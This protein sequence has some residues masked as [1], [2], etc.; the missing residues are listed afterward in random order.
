MKNK[1][2]IRADA[3]KNIGMGHIMRC[4][5][6]AH[7]L[8][9]V[10]C[11]FLVSDYESYKIIN[12]NDLEGIC[13]NSNYNNLLISEVKKILKIGRENYVNSILVDSYYVTKEYLEELKKYFYV[14]C[15]N[16]SNNYLPADYIINYN[17]N[18]DRKIYQNL[19]KASKTKLLLGSSYVPLREEFLAKHKEVTNKAVQQIL[20]MTGGSD[21]YNF[22]GQFAEKICTLQECKR[23][24]FV[25]I[26][27]PYNANRENLIEKVNKIKNMEIQN[28]VKNISTIMQNSDLVISAGGTTLYELCAI[29]VPAIVFAFAENQIEEAR[30]MGEKMIVKYVG[31]YGEEKFWNNVRN[32]ILDLIKS[33]PTRR[34]MGEEMKKAVDGKGA[35]RIVECIKDYF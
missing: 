33:S 1:I 2:F 9:D 34:K 5:T 12:D 20:V 22:M 6:V 18:C 19:Y 8:K 30:F 27:G 35:Y 4:I 29:G 17:I 21:P 13:L 25:F 11:I 32:A 31:Q 28:N 23:I 15:F 3:N 10:D 7:A 26:S 24:R 16:C 14:G